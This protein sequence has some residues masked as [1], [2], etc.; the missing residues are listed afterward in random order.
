MSS[1]TGLAQTSARHG[2]SGA[3]YT[4]RGSQHLLTPEAG[5]AGPAV[6][7]RLAPVVRG[8]MEHSKFIAAAMQQ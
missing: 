5:L 3:F 8:V 4:D 7:L 1:F 2:L 6:F